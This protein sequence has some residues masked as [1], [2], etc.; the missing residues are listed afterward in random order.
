MVTHTNSILSIHLGMV[1]F[2]FE[3]TRALSA[4]EGALL[5]VDATQGIQAQTLAHLYTAI[6]QDLAIVPI[7]NKIDLASAWPERIAGE[8]ED[9][10]SVEAE[11]IP[12]ISAKN[13]I[14]I[15]QV[16]EAIIRD[17]P[18]PSGNPDAPLRC[19]V[20]DCHYDAF[21]GVIANV[22]VVD[23][24]LHEQ[25]DLIGINSGRK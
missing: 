24:N 19:L 3:V 21:K 13:E 8:L 7:I 2:S 25:D 11:S 4:C 14:N 12:R 15:D 18:A 23:G 6:D 5:V 16:L 22:R 20:F 1:D 9:L 10:L 17:I